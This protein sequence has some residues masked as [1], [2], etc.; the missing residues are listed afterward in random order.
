MICEAEGC[1][2]LADAHLTEID[3]DAKREAHY[4][5]ECCLA[6]IGDAAK[7]AVLKAVS[8]ANAS[9]EREGVKLLMSEI[10][11]WVGG[12]DR[13][14][15]MLGKP[16]PARPPQ[17]FAGASEALEEVDVTEMTITNSL[18]LITVM[19][20]VRELVPGWPGLVARAKEHYESLGEDA[21]ALL[22]GFL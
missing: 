16:V 8:D 12:T 18:A 9:P 20:P 10:D 2:E 11:P 7:A 14:M 5:E 1:D 19:N 17:I 21:G 15:S 6:R 4:C 3:G 22:A 13:V